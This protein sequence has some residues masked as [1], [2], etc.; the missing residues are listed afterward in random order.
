MSVLS[1]VLDYQKTRVNIID[2]WLQAYFQQFL[3]FVL[4]VIRTSAKL[5]PELIK[6]F[7][8]VLQRVIVYLPQ[9][10]FNC[11]YKPAI[12]ELCLT[13]LELEDVHLTKQLIIF[14][15]IYIDSAV[16]PFE[17]ERFIPRVVAMLFQALPHLNVNSFLNIGNLLRIY[18][19]VMVSTNLEHF[20]SSCTWLTASH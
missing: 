20:I 18:F 14:I 12:E 9:V 15:E 19:K 3:G 13:A 8:I 16:T 1:C 6:A 17:T 4:E 2:E 11:T 5:N 10:L 7:S